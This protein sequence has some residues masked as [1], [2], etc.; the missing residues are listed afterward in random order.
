M[1]KL[2]D[3]VNANPQF[4][5]GAAGAASV[6]ALVVLIMAL[7]GGKPRSRVVTQAWYLDLNSRK[8]FPGPI[9][10]VPPIPAPSGAYQGGNGGA[11]A[12]VFGCGDCSESDRR[13]A[14]LEVYTPKAAALLKADIERRSKAE[15]SGPPAGYTES[16]AIADGHFIAGEDLKWVLMRDPKAREVRKSIDRFRDDC[17]AKGAMLTPC[18]P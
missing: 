1:Q 2:R 10:E 12:H 6:L 15:P 9:R 5:L 11:L 13:I 4:A 18:L 3:W 8:L 17:K 14:F 16:Q 7:S